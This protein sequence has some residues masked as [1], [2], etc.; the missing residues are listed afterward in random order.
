MLITVIIS[1]LGC[2]TF[3]ATETEPVVKPLS[4]ADCGWI[5]SKLGSVEI[6]VPEVKTLPLPK[7]MQSDD[8]TGS[9]FV[10]YISGDVVVGNWIAF[11]DNA[12]Y[13]VDLGVEY[14]GDSDLAPYIQITPTGTLTVRFIV[15]NRRAVPVPVDE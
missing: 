8:V 14:E 15:E 1:L 12:I 2:S 3:N 4:S 5:V 9:C 13:P 11:V 6:T 7:V 10:G